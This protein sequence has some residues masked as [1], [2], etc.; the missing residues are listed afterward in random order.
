[1]RFTALVRL[2]AQIGG[3]ADLEDKVSV[4]EWLSLATQKRLGW[5]SPETATRSL[6]EFVEEALQVHSDEIAKWAATWAKWSEE[7]GGDASHPMIRQKNALQ[8]RLDDE[9][10]FIAPINAAILNSRHLVPTGFVGPGRYPPSAP[11]RIAQATQW[12]S[13]AIA[14][15]LAMEQYPYCPLLGAPRMQ[16]EMYLRIGCDKLTSGKCSIA[17]A[18]RRA[19]GSTCARVGILGVRQISSSETVGSSDCFTSQSGD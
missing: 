19:G 1:M 7:T 10:A 2:L 16:S 17:E 6:L 14:S 18:K 11:E 4:F 9:T 13:N 12:Y 8:A 3:E 15:I 5:A